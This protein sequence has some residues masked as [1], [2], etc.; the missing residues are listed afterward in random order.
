M[1]P[2]HE[3][4]HCRL[5]AINY[6]VVLMNASAYSNYRKFDPYLFDPN[7]FYKHGKN[8]AFESWGYSV[9]DGKW[10]Q[11][12]MERQAR[13]KYIAGDYSLGKLDAWGQRINI[14][15][16][17]PRKDGSG[18]VTFTGGWMVEPNGKIKLNTPY[19]GE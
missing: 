8:K 13:E 19:G 6:L 9:D 10:L 14:V 2:H 3:K 18:V 5:E 15:V 17:I 4:C 11:A 1:W 7:N 12:E 16:E